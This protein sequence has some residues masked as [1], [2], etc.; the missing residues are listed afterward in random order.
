[1]KFKCSSKVEVLTV[2]CWKGLNRVTRGPIEIFPQQV[3]PKTSWTYNI[4]ILKHVNKAQFM[5]M[6][7]FLFFMDFPKPACKNQNIQPRS[8]R[9]H[10]PIRNPF[11]YFRTEPS[12]TRILDPI[13]Y[14]KWYYGFCSSKKSESSDSRKIPYASFRYSSCTNFYTTIQSSIGFGQEG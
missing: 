14:F 3:G 2:Y 13:Q 9:S 5:K 6:G 1:M 8:V 12:Q 7:Y 4:G 11:S 10:D